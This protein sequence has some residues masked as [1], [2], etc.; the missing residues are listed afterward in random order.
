MVEHD[1]LHDADRVELLNG[2]LVEKVSKGAPH[3]LL[4]ERVLHWLAPGLG[5][6]RYR[7]R[8]ESALVVP[9]G[10][11]LPEPDLMVLDAVSRPEL[12]SSALLVIEVADTSLRYD[13]SV[14]PPL[15]AA[16]GVPEY[17]SIDARGRDVRVY[18]EPGP[19]GYRAYRT[20]S[21]GRLAASVVDV[22]ALDV[23][24]LFA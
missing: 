6:D 13:R 15:Y 19:T 24:A 1:L 23:D 21:E 14:K 20:V 5:A 16:S 3:E 9:D 7:V 8:V 10:I 18:T 11:S 17:W 22:A 4:K 12:P 2:V